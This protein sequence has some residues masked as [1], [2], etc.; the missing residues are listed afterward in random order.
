MPEVRKSVS[1]EEASRFTPRFDA[2]GLIPCITVDASD[3][4]VLMFAWMNRESLQKTLE[5]GFVHYWSRSRQEIWKKG[6]TS[7]A[8][9]RVVEVRT[10][11]D[12][13]VVLIK[14][15]VDDRRGTCHTGRA[16]C[17]YRSVP[18]GSGPV[19]RQF[20]SLDDGERE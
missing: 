2:E 20:G 8:T 11:C 14:A 13:D 6:E 1:I 15:A 18:L 9:Q 12:Q 7:G 4:D 19:E 10:D 5:T 16:S 3:G 17:F